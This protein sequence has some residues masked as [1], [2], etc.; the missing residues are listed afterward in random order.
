MLSVQQDGVRVLSTVVFFTLLHGIKNAFTY[1]NPEAYYTR[2]QKTTITVQP[3]LQYLQ[4][5]K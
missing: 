3:V 4:K 2:I 5:V 1:N